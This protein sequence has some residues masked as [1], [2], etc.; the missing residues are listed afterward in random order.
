MMRN[1]LLLFMMFF[2]MQATLHAEDNYCYQK[3]NKCASGNILI[4]SLAE[5]VAK[6]CDFD[7]QVVSVERQLDRAVPLIMKK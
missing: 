3:P 2:C 1:L 5:D 7:K 6:Y 4:L